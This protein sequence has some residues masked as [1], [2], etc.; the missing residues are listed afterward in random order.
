MPYTKNQKTKGASPTGNL[1][2]RKQRPRHKERHV[3]FPSMQ[4]AKEGAPLEKHTV[5]ASNMYGPWPMAEKAACI[6]SC[7][8]SGPSILNK[9]HHSTSNADRDQA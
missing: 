6:E 1:L 9:I 7:A 2:T 5:D 8:T 3:I 4:P